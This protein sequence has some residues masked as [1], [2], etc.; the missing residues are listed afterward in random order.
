MELVSSSMK[1]EQ[2]LCL[3]SYKAEKYRLCYTDLML[4]LKVCLRFT[5][6][7]VS[8]CRTGCCVFCSF[9]MLILLLYLK[10][11]L[12]V[13]NKCHGPSLSVFR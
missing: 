7:Y 6:G 12:N 4:V 1:T 9:M 3:I 8:P 11:D 10:A 5:S 2:N 13:G